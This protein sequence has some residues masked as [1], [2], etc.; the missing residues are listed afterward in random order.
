MNVLVL[1][2][3]GFIGSS[4]AEALLAAGASVTVFD[5]IGVDRRNLAAVASRLAWIEGDF[6]NPRDLRRA[7]AGVDVAVHLVG[8]TPPAGSLQSPAFDA[9]A[10]IVG[11]VRLFELCV[12]AGVRR[13]VFASSGGTVYGIPQGALL[14]ESHPLQPISPYG[15]AKLAVE[16]YLGAFAYQSGL[17]ATILRLSNPYGPRQNPAAGQ[18]VIAT[19]MHGL[20]RGAPVDLYGDGSVVRDYLHVDDAAAALCA[21]TLAPSAPDRLRVFNAGSGQGHSLLD[22]HALLER[23]VQAPVPLRRHEAR[24]IDVPRNV[25]DVA[26]IREALGWQAGIGLEDGMR[27]MW[28]ALHGAA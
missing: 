27:A 3:C 6:G 2:G 22:L 19:W 25:L 24:R 18:G 14:H 17:E 9:E 11:S 23:V 5:R 8:T 26:A 12:E 28:R 21:A 7:L 13:V 1:G 4:L 20:L 16:K 15:A 10:S